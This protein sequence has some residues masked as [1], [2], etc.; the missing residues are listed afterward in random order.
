MAGEYTG[1]VMKEGL[2]KFIAA[3]RPDLLAP[4]KVPPGAWQLARLRCP[5]DIHCAFVMQKTFMIGR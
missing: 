5:I 1:A 4:R 2:R 3:Y